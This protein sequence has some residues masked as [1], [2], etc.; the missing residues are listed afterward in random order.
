MQKYSQY[1]A[2]AI[3][4]L[5]GFYSWNW[6]WN[7]ILLFYLLDGLAKEIVLHLKSNKIYETQGGENS[8]ITWKKSGV[9]SGAIALFVTVILHFMVYI[10][11]PEVNFF[12]EFIRFLSYKEM[13]LA[14]GWVLLPLIALNVWMQFK[15]TFLKFG[16]HTKIQLSLLWK[17]HLR[18]R[19]FYLFAVIIGLGLHAVV[20][21]NDFVFVWVSV[22]LPLIY[23]AVF[24][25]KY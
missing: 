18:Y 8:K 3:I 13:G 22:G 23:V 20:H 21:F 11:N 1:L 4:P 2:E 15:F 10:S 7:F 17:E 16:L 14:Q 24:K 12:E 9:M 6:S 5:L 19:Y 25:P